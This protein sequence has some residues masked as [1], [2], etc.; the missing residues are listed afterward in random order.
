MKWLYECGQLL[1]GIPDEEGFCGCGLRCDG[2]PY[3]ETDEE[4]GFV[5]N[6][7]GWRR[8]WREQYE[9]GEYPVPDEGWYDPRG[10]G[11]TGWWANGE[12]GSY[13]VDVAP[14]HA[15][16]AVCLNGR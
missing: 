2:R 15:W 8:E 3:P 11:I 1:E 9:R 14:A 7:M 10:E 5:S 4:W 16:R 13:C 6:W 12:F